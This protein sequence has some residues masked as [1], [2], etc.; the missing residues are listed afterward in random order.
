M[1]GLVCLLPH[2]YEGQGP[3][4]S[5]ARLERFLQL[6]AEDNMQV[7]NC[8]TPANYFHILRRQLKRDIRKPLI[9]MTPKSLL[10]HKRA[11]S[12]LD[13][14]AAGSSFHRLLLDDAEEAASGTTRLVEDSGIRRVILCSGKV[15]YDLF[16][17]REKRGVNDIYLLRVEQLYPFP[18]KALV[19]I[20]SR[21]KQA[22][23]FWCQEEPKNMGAWHF[24]GPYLDWVLTQTGCKT[25]RPL[26][27]GRPASAA[28]ATGLMPKHLAE[29]KAVINEV[30]VI[31][32]R[33]FGSGSNQ[34]LGSRIG[35]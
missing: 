12:K 24:V 4:H 11:V 23:V 8:T 25:K 13:E 19:A 1:S 10:R 15:Y 14:F 17:E 31:D 35:L 26:Y 28:T 6:C 30:F 5:S 32:R 21:F 18:L 20:L 3:E 29:I 33:G 34:P 16:E 22:E 7:A 27:A 9:L 2:G